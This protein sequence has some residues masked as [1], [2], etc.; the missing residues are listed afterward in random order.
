MALM[1]YKLLRSVKAR[2]YPIPQF[3]PSRAFHLSSWIYIY[4]YIVCGSSLKTSVDAVIRL[5]PSSRDLG[6]IAGHV[7]RPC[8]AFRSAFQES[9]KDHQGQHMQPYW[10][11][12]GSVTFIRYHNIRITWFK[13]CG[14]VQIVWWETRATK[15]EL[16]LGPELPAGSACHQSHPIHRLFMTV[17]PM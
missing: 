2:N 16:L 8:H 4:I 15:S 3:P 13:L 5:R 10:S 9:T 11:R 6:T 7:G 12:G 1:F 14:G 17:T